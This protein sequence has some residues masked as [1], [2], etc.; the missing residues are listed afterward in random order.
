MRTSYPLSKFSTLLLACLVTGSLQ[1]QQGDYAVNSKSTITY[2]PVANTIGPAVQIMARSEKKIMLS[3]A[4]FGEG[5]SHYV[6]ERS[7][8]G[9]H[10]EEAGLF[11]TGEWLNEPRYVYA[12]KLKRPYAGPLFYRLRV[13]GLNG[14]EVYSSA[15]ISGANELSSQSH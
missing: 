11:F 2:A 7:A 5:V 3:W 13:V 15:S 9:R 6:L 1:A 4:P 12:D 8:D 10:Y 14:S